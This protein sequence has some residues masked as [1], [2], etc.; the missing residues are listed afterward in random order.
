MFDAIGCAK[1]GVPVNELLVPV[2]NL[3]ISKTTWSNYIN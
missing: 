3:A 1:N 2:L